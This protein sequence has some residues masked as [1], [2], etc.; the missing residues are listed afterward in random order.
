MK[1]GLRAQLRKTEV[2]GLHFTCVNEQ[3]HQ[4]GMH[5]ATPQPMHLNFD[6]QKYKRHILHNLTSQKVKIQDTTWLHAAAGV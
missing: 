6:A 3:T 5:E 4:R 2:F 1:T